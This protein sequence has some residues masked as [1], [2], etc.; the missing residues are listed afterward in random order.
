MVSHT[1]PQTPPATL[2]TLPPPPAGRTGWPWDESA[3][4]IPPT[5]PDGRPWP[6]ITVV[7][8][9]FN[10]AEF[11][12][13][14]L[15]S[16]LLQGYPA[17][18]YLVMDG[19]S[20]DGSREIIERYAPWLAHWQ[21]QP[22][23]GQADA[24]AQ[25]LARAQG[26]IF[27]FINSDDVLLPGALATVGAAL[28]PGDGVGLAGVV[29]D[30]GPEGDSLFVPRDFSLDDFLAH[31]HFHQPGVWLETQTLRDLGGFPTDYD[32]CFDY[33]LYLRLAAHHGHVALTDQPLAVF[34]VHPA[35]KTS[36]HH[37]HFRNERVRALR[38]ALVDVPVDSKPL[39]QRRLRA[40]EREVAR[41][42]LLTRAEHL[43]AGP[44]PGVVARL[45][46]VRQ[47]LGQPRA[48]LNSRLLEVL[49]VGTDQRRVRQALRRE[50]RL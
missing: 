17:L 37:A 13:E 19:G 39:L 15:R 9:S 35:S 2:A 49:V 42:S 41:A 8:P 45:K 21:S 26:D 31:R 6:R 25:G 10:Q 11:L 14:T 47:A 33:A 24:V 44:A 23:G 12:E 46:V 48:A 22:D 28:S 27:N 32:Y 43:L 50:R 4:P 18:D 1:P 16:V 3:A 20:Q 30:R 36:M 40:L 34:R 29:I 38:E 5:R 7:T